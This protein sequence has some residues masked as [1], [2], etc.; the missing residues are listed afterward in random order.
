MSVGR[1]VPR[2]PLWQII[3]LRRRRKIILVIM[4]IIASEYDSSFLSAILLASCFIVR[5]ADGPAPPVIS[6]DVKYFLVTIQVLLRIMIFVRF[7]E[8][9]EA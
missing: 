4:Y 8:D 2:Q 7:F 1:L 3:T 9:F 5:V 6:L